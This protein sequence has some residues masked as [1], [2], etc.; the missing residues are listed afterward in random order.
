M[1][2]LSALLGVAPTYYYYISALVLVILIVMMSRRESRRKFFVALKRKPQNI[3]LVMIT[4]CFI[5]YSFNLS[6]ISLTTTTIHAK[7]GLMGFVIMLVS[8]LA[9]VC[10][11]R[12]FPYRKKAVIPMLVLTFVMLGIVLA[13]DSV[14]LSTVAGKIADGTVTA[15]KVGKETFGNIDNTQKIMIVHIVMLAVAVLLTA[16]LP[17]YRKWIR[18]INTSIEVA[19]NAEMGT[20]DISGE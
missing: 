5:W 2:L 18:K 10:C 17:V 9:V 16:T 15:E 20:I 8:V 6:A 19:E 13:C 3:P 4:C 1:I 7:T 11:M 12:A 14:Y